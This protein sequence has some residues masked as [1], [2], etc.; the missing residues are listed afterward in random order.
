MTDDRPFTR[1]VLDFEIDDAEQGFLA[2]VN[3]AREAYQARNLSEVCRVRTNCAEIASILAELRYQ[4][5]ELIS[6]Q[7]S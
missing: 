1:E 5:R 7:Q 2:S 3:L 6:G 4:R